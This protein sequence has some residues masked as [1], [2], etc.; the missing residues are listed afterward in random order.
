MFEYFTTSFLQAVHNRHRIVRLKFRKVQ[1]AFLHLIFLSIREKRVLLLILGPVH[2]NRS[3]EQFVVEFF[4][5]VLV[6]ASLDVVIVINQH[7]Q[8]G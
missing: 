3:V 4:K 8:G 7:S 2:T 6:R 5:C 1:S